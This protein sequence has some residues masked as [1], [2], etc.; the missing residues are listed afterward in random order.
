MN[1]NQSDPSESSPD[2]SAIH[3]R[4]TTSVRSHQLKIR[5]LTTAAFVLGFLAVAASFLLV[6]CYLIF[7]LPKQKQLLLEAERTVQQAKANPPAEVS[8]EEAVKRLDKF[9]GVQI[10]MTYVVSMGTTA[11]AIMVGILGFGTLIVL[12]VVV[13]GRRATLNQINASLAQISTHLKALPASGSRKET[14]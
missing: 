4:V 1:Q 9:M 12:A 10:L 11:V 7:Y 2:L 5:V 8:V 13:L 6:W 14:S 3:E